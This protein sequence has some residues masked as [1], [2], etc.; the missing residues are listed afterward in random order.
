MT[1][2]FADNT[3]DDTVSSPYSDYLQARPLSVRERLNGEKETLGLYLTG[4][5]I[6]EYVDELVL[7]LP[8]R[9]S[10]LRA[11]K[12]KTT[13]YGMVIGMR[14][15][16]NKRGENFAF[17]TLDDKSGRIEVSVWAEKF[18]AYREILVKDALLVV[19]GV[20]SE[21]S[22]S[23]GFKM[24]AES[25]QSIY[26]ARCTKLESLRLTI[27][28]QD[29][30]KNWVERIESTL[31]HF[32]NGSCPVTIEYSMSNAVGQFNLG[33]QWLVQPRDELIEQLRE[34]FGKNNVILN[35]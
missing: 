17:L 22:Y 32:K 19:Q 8:N 2:L 7:M 21:D 29:T 5:P 25:I 1:D 14:V 35:Y 18:N 31:S 3:S 6:D 28:K 12:D 4:H 20:V 26:Q 13:I 34:Q 16:K 30:P 15:M 23:G 10:D 27:P 9:I 24:V 11:N 33:E